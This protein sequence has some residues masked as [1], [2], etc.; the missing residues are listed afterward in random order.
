MARAQRIAAGG[1]LFFHPERAVI[2]HWQGFVKIKITV[3]RRFAVRGP[4][5][6]TDRAIGLDGLLFYGGAECM[7][8]TVRQPG[9]VAAQAICDDWH[10]WDHALSCS[11]HAPTG[12]IITL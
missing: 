2:R 8:V 1:V 3:R 4:L 12:S 9:Y 6:I 7:A 5:S 11:C 10:D